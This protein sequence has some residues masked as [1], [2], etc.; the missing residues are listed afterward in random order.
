MIF[1]TPSLHY[2]RVADQIKDLMIDPQSLYPSPSKCRPSLLYLRS[3]L[4]SGVTK[5][6]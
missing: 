4:P 2:Y 5:D 3:S 1:D 6:E